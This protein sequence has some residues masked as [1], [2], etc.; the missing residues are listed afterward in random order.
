MVTTRAVERVP[1]QR[2]LQC[3]RALTRPLFRVRM[4]TRRYYPGPCRNLLRVTRIRSGTLFLLAASLLIVARAAA[5][6]PQAAAQTDCEPFRKGPLP[7]LADSLESSRR[8]ADCGY[9]LMHEGDYARAQV[10]FV[11]ALD[12]ATRRSDRFAEAMALD[13]YGITLATLGQ[14]EKAETMLQRSLVISE[15][16]GDK[17]GMAEASSQLGHLRNVE[18]RY[19]EAR[20]FHLRSFTLW[21]AIGSER[22][23]AVALN[24]VGAMYRAVGDYAM[25]SEYYQRSLDGLQKMGDRRRSAT[26]IDNLA[27]NARVLGDYTKG[28]ELSREALAIRESFNDREGISRSFTSLSENYRAEGNYSA[29]LDALRKSLALSTEIGNVHAIAETLNN[30]A[31]VYEAQGNYA[32]AADHLRK[33]LALNDAKVHSASLSAEVHTHLG[34]VLFRQGL[35]ATAVRSLE[36]SLAISRT[37]ALT[38]QAAEARLALARVSTRIGQL[39]RAARLLA[40]VLAFQSKTGDRTARAE[41]LIS[42]SEVQRRLGRPAPALALATEA[43]GLAETMELVDVEWAAATAMGRA[44]VALQRTADARLAFDAAIAVVEDMRAQN[45]GGQESRRQFFTDRLAP[46]EERIALALAASKPDDAFY[47]AERSKARALLDVIRSDRV[48]ITSTMTPEERKREVEL[49]TALNSVNSEVFVAAGATPRDAARVASL[50]R[51]RDGRRREY[52]EFQ[53]H[54]Y[55]VHPELQMNRA[56]GAVISAPE[57]QRLLPSPTTAIVEFVAGPQRTHAVVIT[58]AGIRVFEL[59]PGTRELARQVS[60]FCRQLANRDLRAAESARALYDVVLGPMRA[61]LHGRTD[62]IIVP[63]GMLWNLPFQALKPAADRYLIEDSAL[64]YAPSVTVLRETMRR[65]VDAPARPSVLAFGSSIGE[66]PGTG[67]APAAPT[68]GHSVSQTEREATQVAGIYRGS[69]R[70]Y[71][72]TDAREDRWKAE[73]PGYRVVHLATHGVLENASPLYSHLLLAPPVVGDKEDG[74]L[75]AWEI[76]NIHLDA[77]LV[78]LSA[79]ETASGPIAPGEGI[80]GLMWAVFVAGTPST[81]VSQWK[82]DSEG[83]TRLVVGFHDEW[84]GGQRGLTKAHALQKAALRLLKTPGF[85]HPFYWAGFILAGDSR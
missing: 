13:G 18:A 52:E 62:L 65:R 10:L 43:R 27:R 40:E 53:A 58:A 51:K 3:E 8:L 70:V 76:M 66:R 31:V 84:R 32:Q 54:L 49:R 46:Y 47:F 45:G 55:A 81:L 37:S 34:E 28:L 36:R 9:A 78:V 38:L 26:V 35:F 41:A 39:T 59:T 82:V 71:T 61:L 2:G 4:E 19:D 11:A 60:A 14:L 67:A 69:S 80:T 20:E 42:M 85:S 15:E 17:D 74:L 16:I 5:S 25:A 50:Q 77:D 29:A 12:M 68:G 73:A 23:V 72:G 48:P 83:S 44:D 57:A 56:A 24:N 22:G 79:C 64:S 21:Q 7:V 75:E 33:S 1:A 63:D 30:I 6:P